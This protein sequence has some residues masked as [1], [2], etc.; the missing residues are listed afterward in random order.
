MQKVVVGLIGYGYWGPNLVR[1]FF[2][3][4]SCIVKTVVDVKRDRLDLFKKHYPSV[5]ISAKPERLFKDKSIEAIIIATPISTHFLL[6]KKALTSGKHV[7]VEKPM[8]SSFEDAKYLVYLANKKKKI[9][10]VD[11]TFIYTDA[12]QKI[13]RIIDSKIV[14][15]VN[16][17]DSTRTNLGLFQ[18]DV[19]VL[20]DLAAHDISILLYL[21]DG[22]PETVWATGISHTQNGIENIAFVT[23]RY[24]SGLIAHFNCSW[25]SPVKIRLTLIGGTKKMIVYN[26]VEPTE[27]IKIYDSGYK[28]KKTKSE[29]LIDYRVGDIQIPKIEL[30]EGLA[31]MAVDFIEAIKTGKKP[32]SD[33]SHGLEVVK[34][35]TLA[36]ESMR[37]KGQAVSYL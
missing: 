8:A 33:A 15:K 32:I 28:L 2:N 19:N 11:H 29:I 36:Q 20:W 31:Q 35:L 24:K 3:L 6:A 25:S 1:N 10:M 7:L 14:G 18:K 17:F 23:L 5:Q 13:K 22:K 9:L 30:H 27:K 12:V 37:Q 26:D 16:Y 34:I 21:V 4:D